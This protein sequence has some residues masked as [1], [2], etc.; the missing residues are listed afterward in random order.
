M[1]A[2]RNS[3]TRARPALAAPLLAA[4]YFALAV[5]PLALAAVAEEPAGFWTETAS[6]L[7]MVAAVL[8]LLQLVSSGRFEFLSGR[9][10]IDVTMAFHKWMARLLVVLVVAHPIFFVL[11]VDFA[12]PHSAWN[13]LSALFTAPG[14]YTGIL[15]FALVI[16]LVGLGLSR[17][18]L[19]L[20]Y[21]AWRASHGLMAVIAAGAT[22]MHLLAIGTYAR[23]EPL[24][25][26]WIVL[27]FAALALALGVYTV[28][29]WQMHRQDWA[30]SGKR[31]LA[32]RLWE[33]TLTSPSGKRL[34]FEAGQFVWLALAPRRFPLF[35]HPFSIASAPNE[36][37]EVRFLIQ[38]A[39]DFTRRLGDVP[40][41]TPAAIDG[42][43]GSFVLTDKPCDA[44]LLIAGGV[45]L[46]P[47][48][49]MLNDLANRDDGRPVRL[50]Y[51]ARDAEAMVD[52]AVFATALSKLGVTPILLLDKPPFGEGRR[53]G[54]I[55]RDHLAEAMED[56]DPKSLA[57]MICG[58]AGMMSAT[59][60]GLTGLGV[61]PVNIRYERFDYRAG[62][63]TG[64]DRAVI[65]NFRLL[66]LAVGVVMLAFAFRG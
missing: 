56:L 28:R 45:G 4:G 19:P 18:R 42:P 64:K 23:S 53:E 2:K 48:L 3:K 21:E 35:D 17:D 62:P 26:I 49:S 1:T 54:P 63:S 34:A 38:E 29:V 57:V 65:R 7:G 44:V 6:A 59:C 46:A 25:T 12:R 10:G 16:L 24:R 37:G 41:G 36:A 22:L 30:V 50:I 47:V 31:K 5:I 9:I 11:P 52:L 66:A 14:N 13:H 20:T 27:A 33:V 51:A 15:A 55:T 61:P 8:L 39:G 60:E 32:D 40:V 58:P 43:H